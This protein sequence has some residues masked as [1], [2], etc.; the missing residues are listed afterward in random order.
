MDTD[1]QKA[2]KKTKLIIDALNYAHAH[3][4]D[5]ANEADVKN[6]LA[7]I[8]PEN[9]TNDIEEFMNLLLAGN[10]MIEKDVKRRKSMN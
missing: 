9:L 1:H 10:S 5:I 4:L 8:D 7:A 6:I 2:L 3:S